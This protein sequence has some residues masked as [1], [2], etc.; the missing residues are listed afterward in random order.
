MIYVLTLFMLGAGY[1]TLTFGINLWKNEKNK[2]GGFGAVALA[3]IGTIVPLI[4][5]FIKR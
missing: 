3:V 1:Y 4:V 5:M 2:L